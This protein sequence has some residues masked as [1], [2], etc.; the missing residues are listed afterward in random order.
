MERE[1]S[2]LGARC[3]ANGNLVITVPNLLWLWGFA[4]RVGEFILGR[5]LTAGDQPVD[6]WFTAYCLRQLLQ[7][8]FRIVL[9]NGAWYF[10]P[11]GRG[12]AAIQSR[13][14]ASAIRGMISWDIILGWVFPHLGHAMGVKS[15]RIAFPNPSLGE[16]ADS[17]WSDTAQGTQMRFETTQNGTTNKTEKMR[18][19]HNENMGNRTTNQFGS[20]VGVIGIADVTTSP[21]TYPSGGGALYIERAKS[22]QPEEN[23]AEETAPSQPK[24]WEAF[25][26]WAYVA[27]PGTRVRLLQG[28]QEASS[29]SM[30][31]R[32]S[33]PIDS[34]VNLS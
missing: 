14:I 34:T 6:N 22:P 20:G 30:C 25:R 9:V 28:R 4:R 19:D 12:K 17:H 7:D 5:K 32:V 10:P 8:R 2:P 11:L 15:V 23:C 18:L 29:V 1:S 27:H 21:T 31:R 3:A 13:R 16:P 33:R 26:S 24:V